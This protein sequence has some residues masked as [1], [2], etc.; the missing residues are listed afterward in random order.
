[1]DIG[2]IR[3]DFNQH[4]GLE[5]EDLNPNPFFQFESWFQEALQSNMPEPN[6]FSLATVG[7]DGQPSQ[8]TVLL[9]FFDAN[10]LV[11]YT[12]YKSQKALEIQENQKV[13]ALFPWYGLQRQV[14]I[15]GTAEKIPTAQSLAYFLS[16]PRDSQLGAWI[17]PQSEIITSRSLLRQQLEIMKEKFKNQ[18]VPLPDFWGGY[19][20]RPT[21]FEFWQGQPNRLHDRFQYTLNADLTWQINRLAP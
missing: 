19:L 10:G 2:H 20:I 13:S 14:K 6:G 12:N 11:F 17:S 3:K 21:V 9:K 4:S 1:M 8:R 16:R 18:A 5:L 15:K 7:A